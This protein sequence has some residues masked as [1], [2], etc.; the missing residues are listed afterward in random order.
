MSHD[1][2][3]AQ[4][5]L[6][7][8]VLIPNRIYNPRV[9][10][11]MQRVPRHAFVGSR[12]RHLAYEDRTLPL[13]FNQ[14]IL[15]PL[16]QA[17]ILQAMRLTGT[18]RILE[19]GTGSG[20]LTALLI[21]LGGYV[22]SLERDARLAAQAADR[23]HRMGY[24]DVDLHVGDGSQGLADM[25]PFDAIIVTATTPKIPKPLAMQLADGGRMVLPIGN[26]DPQHLNLVYRDGQIWRASMIG[27]VKTKPLIG[28]YGFTS[29]SRR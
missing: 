5:S 21:E 29:Q 25:S 24:Q 4:A 2:R 13:P 6:I 17:Q 3:R 1:F 22:F 27:T 28:R 16:I 26:R 20:Y 14:Q 7:H 12:W 23:L 10:E 15:S 19:I 18:E 8:R 9:L 11:V